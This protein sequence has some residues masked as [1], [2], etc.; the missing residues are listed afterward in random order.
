M[1][2][3]PQTACEFLCQ[4]APQCLGGPGCV[5]ECEGQAPPGCESEW[6]SL[7]FCA[8]PLL[9]PNCELDGSECSQEVEAYAQ[10]DGDDLD[11]GDT[12]CFSTM[13]ECGC[14]ANCEGAFV[15]THCEF[16]GMGAVE[17]QCFW[18][19]VFLGTCLQGSLECDPEFA[20]C[21]ELF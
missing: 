6:D 19:G 21:N 17:C 18:D 11:C 14:E 7:I 1:T 12:S 13:G 4:E 10:C 16:S 8:A 15:E 3:G 2:T 5:E 20:C 9:G